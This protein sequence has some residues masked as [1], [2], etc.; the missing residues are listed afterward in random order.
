M[1]DN[2]VGDVGDGDDSTTVL[3]SGDGDERDNYI[4]RAKMVINLHNHDNQIFEMVRVSCLIQNKVP[5]LCERNTYTDFPN[6][7]EGTVFTS[8]YEQFVS[9]AYQLLQNT[10]ELDNQAE[11]GLEIFKKF[12]MENFLKEVL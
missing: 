9:K 10:K 6:Y 3:R 11:K 1:E 4:K 8:P 12:P 5:V 7:M 2:D